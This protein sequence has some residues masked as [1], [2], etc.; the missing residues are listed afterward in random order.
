MK[1]LKITSP[2]DSTTSSRF[3]RISMQVK[4]F[5]KNMMKKKG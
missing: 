4:I 3:V 2:I 1:R 5:L